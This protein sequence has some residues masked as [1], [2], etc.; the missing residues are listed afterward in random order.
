MGFLGKIKNK[1]KFFF[2]KTRKIPEEIPIRKVL[3]LRVNL[4]LKNYLGFL[5]GFLGKLKNKIKKK[6]KKT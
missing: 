4:I 1:K 2:K 5:L 6:Y 3:L